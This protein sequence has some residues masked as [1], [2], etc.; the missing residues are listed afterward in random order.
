MP[1]ATTYPAARN[2]TIGL[3][4]HEE[5]DDRQTEG[6]GEH[7]LRKKIA[8]GFEKT[9]NIPMSRPSSAWMGVRKIMMRRSET[10][11][12]F[13]DER[14]IEPTLEPVDE[15]H[16]REAQGQ[17][18][19]EDHDERA[20]E[21]VVLPVLLVDRDEAGDR[22]VE[23]EGHDACSEAHDRKRVGKGAVVRFRQ[24]ADDQDL[25]AEVDPEREEPADQEQARPADLLPCRLRGCGA[26]G[27]RVRG[28]PH[29]HR[30][31]VGRRASS[32][33]SP[34]RPVQQAA[35][36]S[37]SSHR[38]SRVSGPSGV[39][40]RSRRAVACWQPLPSRS[41]RRLPRLPGARSCTGPGR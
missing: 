6:G 9:A 36:A 8:R 28:C 33:P 3:A 2:S 5:E 24:V 15:Q 40:R 29:A 26:R 19:P 37:P 22:A 39:S 27:L 14:S 18:R 38:S 25:D 34:A 41:R 21:L 4:E 20:E 23:S 16:D 13:A 10:A 7:V 30:S 17:N 35:A 31:P 32:I 12:A 11:C 1:P